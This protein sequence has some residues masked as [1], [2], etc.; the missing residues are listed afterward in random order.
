MSDV[1]YR[2]YLSSKDDKFHVVCMQYFD[3]YNYDEDKFMTDEYGE[4][5]MFDTEDEA[6]QWMNENMKP[7]FIVDEYKKVKFRREDYLL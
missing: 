6:I 2:I 7:E 4:R 1:Y 5:L 3:E